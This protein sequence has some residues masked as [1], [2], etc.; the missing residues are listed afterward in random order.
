VI[1]SND[2]ST[3]FKANEP[4]NANLRLLEQQ[5]PGVGERSLDV[6]GDTVKETGPSV[7]QFLM[8]DV[9]RINCESAGPEPTPTITPTPSDW[10]LVSR[11]S[12]NSM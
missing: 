2:G 6:D 12:A 11:A 3:F 10:R 5:L 1:I 7:D 4:G 9:L 8:L